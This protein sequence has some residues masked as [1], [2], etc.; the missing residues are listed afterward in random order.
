[1]S[2]APMSPRPERR[3]AWR[4][5]SATRRSSA[6]A[7]RKTSWLLKGAV[8]QLAVSKAIAAASVPFD[9]LS[10]QATS[11]GSEAG[12]PPTASPESSASMEEFRS[13]LRASP[14]SS[15]SAEAVVRALARR[16]RGLLGQGLEDAPVVEGLLDVALTPLDRSRSSP[17]RPLVVALFRADQAVQPGALLP[18]FVADLPY[19]GR[20]A[21][22][23][24]RAQVL[25]VDQVR[26][27][28]N[29]LMLSSSQ[30]ETM[31][32]KDDLLIEAARADAWK[33][34]NQGEQRELLRYFSDYR[35]WWEG[36]RAAVGSR[37]RPGGRRSSAGTESAFD[38][39]GVVH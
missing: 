17:R 6:A 18:V 22:Q 33:L 30:V 14:E 5:P 34:M 26:G 7:L 25:T 27:T 20:A 36:A 32:M 21:P 19:D 13:P 11:E 23:E 8:E 28:C 4:K 1:M 38:V 15:D 35:A 2:F 24:Q 29:I 9:E 10:S 16:T 3:P 37:R 12:S 39:D 31:R